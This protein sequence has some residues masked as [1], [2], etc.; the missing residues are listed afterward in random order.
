MKKFVKRNHL[1]PLLERAGKNARL[2]VIEEGFVDR[3]YRH[4]GKLVPRG[5][6]GAV[7]HESETAVVQALE[8]ALRKQVETMGNQLVSLPARTLCVHGDAPDA[9]VLLKAVRQA[10]EAAGFTIRG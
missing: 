10:L 8:I 2:A 1:T 5:V 4:D 3:R 9:V 6:T 7:I